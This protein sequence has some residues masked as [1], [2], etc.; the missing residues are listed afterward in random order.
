MLRFAFVAVGTVDAKQ[1]EASANLQNT[2]TR[3]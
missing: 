1:T 2:I 3:I